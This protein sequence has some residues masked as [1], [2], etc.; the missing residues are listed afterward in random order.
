MSGMESYVGAQ[1]AGGLLHLI[2]QHLPARYFIF[3]DTRVNVPYY[4]RVSR[5]HGITTRCL[6]R[7]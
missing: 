4:Q 7:L 1:P 5:D 2:F 3:G 6:R